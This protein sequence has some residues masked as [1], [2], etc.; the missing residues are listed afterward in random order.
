MLLR[1]RAGQKRVE[2]VSRI[3]LLQTSYSPNANADPR[4]SNGKRR[5]LMQ[6]YASLGSRSLTDVY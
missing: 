3:V 5:G 6:D 1:R 2:G 4:A